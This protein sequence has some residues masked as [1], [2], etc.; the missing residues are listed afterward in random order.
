M[1][2]IVT[3][4]GMFGGRRGG[5]TTPYRDAVLADSPVAYWRLNGSTLVDSS[6]NALSGIYYNSPTTGEAGPTADSDSASTLFNGTNQYGE[7]SHDAL[8]DITDLTI[9]AWV[10]WAI[11]PDSNHRQIM[12]RG[13]SLSPTN[14]PYRI[15]SLNLSSG[16]QAGF[17]GAING[18]TQIQT[19]AGIVT[20]SWYHY[21]GTFK[22]SGSDT[23]LNSYLN[24]VLQ[25]TNTVTDD[26]P[27][28]I[29]SFFIGAENNRRF[30]NA[31]I[32][33]AALYSSPLSAARIAAHYSAAGY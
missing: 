18:F 32:S 24:G 5:G 31:H 17:F 29:S 10:K 28:R 1:S 23:I 22:K 12:G 16:V 7:I 33:E 13:V 14:V 20:S 25:G 19:N 9:E 21:V 2:G 27:V 15:N 3:Q 26:V 6:G 30:V 11:K 4:A 8:L